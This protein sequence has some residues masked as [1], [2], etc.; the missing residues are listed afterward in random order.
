VNSTA[1]AEIS[2]FRGWVDPVL[3]N[4]RPSQ[5]SKRE[6]LEDGDLSWLPDGANDAVDARCL[7]LV[8]ETDSPHCYCMA[9]DGGG[10]HRF[11][12]AWEGDR[13]RIAGIARVTD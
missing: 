7:A 9:R 2:T 3:P 8:C 1:D 10:F 13:P 4:A 12:F 6:S 5:T 11:W